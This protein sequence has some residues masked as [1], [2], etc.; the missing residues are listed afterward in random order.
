MKG[1]AFW[2]SAVQW[3]RVGVGGVV[4]LVAARSLPVEAIGAFGIAAA[5]LRL[6]QVIHKGGVEDAAVV[7]DPADTAGLA[8]LQRVSVIAGLGAAGL[9][10]ATAP[11]VG[12]AGEGVTA[13]ALALGLVPMVH[14]AGAVADG[15]LRRAA[16]FRALAL[17]TLAGQAAAAGLAFWAL[18]AGAGVWALVGFTLVQAVI[19]TALAV[20]MAGWVRGPAGDVRAAVARVWPLALRV[21]AGGLVQPVLQ[22]AIGA[23]AGLAA[24]GVWQIAVR[25]V[26]LLEALTVVPLRFVALP[27]LAR[28][29]A[30]E[31]PGLI[32]AAG[33]AGVWVMG[34]TALAAPAMV[35]AL[36]GPEGAPVVPVLQVLCAG[37]VAGGGVAVL[38]QAL[39]GAGR[40]H[41]ALRVAVI[42]A[43]AALV[44]GGVALAVWPGG[45]ALALSQVAAGWL[46]LALLLR[47]SG[48]GLAAV[49]RPWGGIVAMAPAVWAAG[50]LAGGT[51]VWGVLAAQV[52]AGTAALAAVMWGAR[53]RGR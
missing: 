4:F 49:L 14:G 30:G 41:A 37:A 2:A 18:W 40:G 21:L 20:G 19:A 22:V 17:R 45:V 44:A 10:L 9:A 28:G 51:G 47:G 52:V 33:L 13:L 34:G 32:R 24:A 35:E 46:A 39:I 26:G 53:W 36:L 23:V 3:A 7:T 15:Q 48:V 31:V 11:L 27:R 12:L 38:N 25:V 42:A 5:P 50:W 8:A 16:R 29:G 1:E 6:L 43:G